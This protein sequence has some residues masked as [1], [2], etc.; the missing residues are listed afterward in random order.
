M[1]SGIIYSCQFLI[2]SADQPGL[3]QQIMNE[4]GYSMDDLLAEQRRTGYESRKVNPVIREAFREE[5]SEC[6]ECPECP[7]C[8]RA[9]TADELKMFGG[10]CEE[11]TSF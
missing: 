5:S 6:P 9:T 3:A 2:I 4:S 1:I 7:E 8:L 11:C 10:M